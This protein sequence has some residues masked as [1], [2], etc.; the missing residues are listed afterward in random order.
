MVDQLDMFNKKR[1][2]QLISKEKRTEIA[3]LG[4]LAVSKNKEHMSKIGRKGGQTHD[5]DFFVK[6]GKIGGKSSR[7]KNQ[8]P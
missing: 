6:I 4:G 5:R 1:G 2:F 7:K 3:R 8:Q